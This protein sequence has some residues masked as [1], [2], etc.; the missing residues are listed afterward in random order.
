M[1]LWIL[2]ESMRNITVGIKYCKYIF[3]P[4]MALTDL[5]KQPSWYDISS[6]DVTDFII[7]Q[8]NIREKISLK[9][10][11]PTWLTSGGKEAVS[12][13]LHIRKTTIFLN[14]IYS[15]HKKVRAKFNVCNVSNNEVFRLQFHFKYFLF[16]LK[17]YKINFSKFVFLTHFRAEKYRTVQKSV[18]FFFYNGKEAGPLKR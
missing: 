5:K 2:F 4:A 12:Q 17:L 14:I 18:F 9:F 1:Q 15:F 11:I 3:A 13:Q 8:A 7:V 6:G 16:G 10:L